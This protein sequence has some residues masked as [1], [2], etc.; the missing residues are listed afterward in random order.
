MR[1]YVFHSILLSFLSLTLI[2]AL[3]AVEGDVDTSFGT[4]GRVT[5]DIDNSSK[6]DGLE[7]IRQSDGKVIAVGATSDRND[8]ATIRYNSDGSLDDT[9]GINGIRVEDLGS[10]FEGASGVAIDSNGNIIVA[11]NKDADFAIIRYKSNGS[12]DDSFDTNGTLTANLTIQDIIFDVAIDEDDKIVILG[13]TFNGNEQDITLQRYNTDGT[14]DNTFGTMG[15]RIIP[16]GMGKVASLGFESLAIQSDGKI[17]IVCSNDGLFTVIR[18]NTDGSFDNSFDTDGMNTTT[19]NSNSIETGTSVKLQSDGKIIAA[20][21][22]QPNAGDRDFVIARFNTDGSL[23]DTFNTSGKNIT[24]FGNGDDFLSSVAIQ[25]NGKI[26][27]GG[28]V[29]GASDRDIGLVRYN[30]DGSLDNQ[31]TFGSNGDATVTTDLGSNDN[32]LSILFDA[33]QLLVLIGGSEDFVLGRYITTESGSGSGGSSG[34][35]T[36]STTGS[37]SSSSGGCSLIR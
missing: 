4:D 9:F 30:S 20:G 10:N 16:F 29:A 28:G 15:T 17:V 23:D 34:S 27:A 21:D 12:L 2:T 24:D 18:L 32:A 36:G 7:I 22:S 8:F 11:G 31:A 1:R 26:I 25:D 33:E 3:H 19:F 5:T 37:G 6:D 13:T 35:G 14:L